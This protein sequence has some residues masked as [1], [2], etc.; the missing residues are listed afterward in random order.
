M[1]MFIRV[2]HV[3]RL[4]CIRATFRENHNGPYQYL[5]TNPLNKNNLQGYKLIKGL[6]DQNIISE[7]TFQ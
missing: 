4:I 7:E 2:V 5:R 6:K 1:F 3:K